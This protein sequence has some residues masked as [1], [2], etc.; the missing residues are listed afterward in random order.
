MLWKEMLQDEG[1]LEETLAFTSLVS[2]QYEKSH[3]RLTFLSE[4]VF[5]RITIL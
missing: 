2:I 5:L 3:P 4:N 1:D